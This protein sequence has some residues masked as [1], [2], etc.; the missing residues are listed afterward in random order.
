MKAVDGDYHIEHMMSFIT[1]SVM[2][3]TA[4]VV[5]HNMKVVAK[6]ICVVDVETGKGGLYVGN[7]PLPGADLP[8]Y[9]KEGASKE[10]SC[11]LMVLQQSPSS[12]TQHIWV[13]VQPAVIM[14]HLWKGSILDALGW[15][16]T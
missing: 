2:P 4:V 14:T 11:S 7:D 8:G 5:A 9:W 15:M 13:S 12:A 6:V 16:A 10:D 3:M 1:K